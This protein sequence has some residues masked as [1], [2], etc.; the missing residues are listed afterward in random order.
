MKRLLMIS[1]P[2]PP[3]SSAGAL[4]SERFARHLSKLGWDVNVIT[5]KPRQDL[6]ADD[7]RLKELKKTVRVNLTS[8]LDPWLWLRDKRPEN[9]IL[10]AF[11]SIL[12]KIFS[13]PDNRSQVSLI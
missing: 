8:T 4:R 1:Y 12:M 10:R 13:F 6:F 5:I 11:R 3:N 2:F 7:D 9:F